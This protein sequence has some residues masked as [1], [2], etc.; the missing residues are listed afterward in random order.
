MLLDKNGRKV[1]YLRLSV[2]DRCNLRCTYCMPPEGVAKKPREEIISFD[3][4]ARVVGLLS[5][6]GLEKLRIT[7]GE[8]LVRGGLI[9]FVDRIKTENPTLE[10]CLTTNGV[11]LPDF[12]EELIEAGVSR[13]NVS[14]DTLK[15]DK[16]QK[17]TRFDGLDRV[18]EAVES[19][20]SREI[21]PVKVNTLIIPGFNDDE[22][23][24][25]VEFA[26][27]KPIE[28]RFIERMPLPGESPPQ[29]STGL[30]AS[31]ILEN[32]KIIEIRRNTGETAT[33]YEIDGF[34]GKVGLISPLSDSFCS[35]CNRI[36][37][38]ADGKILNCLLFGSEYDL[39]SL[40]RSGASDNEIMSFI[41]KALAE[42]PK[43]NPPSCLKSNGYLRKC[44]VEVGG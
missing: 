5:K 19:L 2:T 37:I 32:F 43:G 34:E 6:E 7:G 39:K 29:T 35:D 20:I 11:L 42:K 33:I 16:F 26:K 8:P 12:L 41:K 1:T 15:K 44:M 36:R 30:V 9:E 22:I 31:Y 4:M 38:T 3:E 24:D 21:Y 18:L 40:M 27:R 14:L 23:P 25:L 10:I 28:L 17:I 13:F